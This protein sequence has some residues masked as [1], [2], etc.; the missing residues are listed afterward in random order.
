MTNSGIFI[1]T[2]DGSLTELKSKQYDSE[3]LLQEFLEQYPTLI[4]GDQIDQDE[5]RK[6]LH[7]KR[8]WNVPDQDDGNGRWAVDHLF[9]DQDAIPTLVEVKRSSDTRIR[10][11]VVGQMLDYA[12]NAVLYWSVEKIKAEFEINCEGRDPVNELSKLFENKIEYANYW[13]QVKI[14]LQAGKIRLIFIADEIPDELKRI[15]E[16]LNDQMDPAQVLGVEVKQFVGDQLTTFIP[17]V[18][19]QT[20]KAN[21]RK[22]A[23]RTGRQWNKDMFMQD[24]KNRDSAHEQKIAE[25][26][27]EWAQN[28]NLRIWWGKGKIYGSFF[29]ILDLEKESFFTFSVWTYGTIEVLFQ[30]MHTKSI[31]KDI[32]K[33]KELQNKLNQ[34]PSIQ[35]PDHA[36]K[37]RPSFQISAL[38]DETDL[39]SFLQIWDEYINDIKI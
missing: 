19:G 9:L 27:L 14:N 39:K 20:S 4:S 7:I 22:K 37:I 10:R 35:I 24:L 30:Y 21:S 1:R 31:F 18:I 8:E 23:S 5:P 26:L 38:K 29:P 15:I 6:W 32:E 3:A 13:Q 12:A 36:L 28:K 16:F 2:K 11:E 33:R 34:I 25:K 17:R